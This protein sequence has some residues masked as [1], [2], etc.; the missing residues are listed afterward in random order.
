MAEL[1]RSRFPKR[2]RH[3]CPAEPSLSGCSLSCVTLSPNSATCAG[4]FC[5]LLRVFAAGT[6]V[7]FPCKLLHRNQTQYR[8]PE[9]VVELLSALWKLARPQGGHLYG[10]EYRPAQQQRC[11]FRLRRPPIQPRDV[12]S[13]PDGDVR[14]WRECLAAPSDAIS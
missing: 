10:A 11:A 4:L 12:H 6:C 3:G 13:V 8:N 7:L 2:L 1:L 9:H 5:R 14:G